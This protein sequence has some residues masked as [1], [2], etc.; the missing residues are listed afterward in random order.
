MVSLRSS[1]SEPRIDRYL[2]HSGRIETTL[3]FDELRQR[4]L[5]NAAAQSADSGPDFS[6]RIRLS[7]PTIPR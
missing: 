5:I 4:S 1:N 3:S 6:K 7:V 2:Y